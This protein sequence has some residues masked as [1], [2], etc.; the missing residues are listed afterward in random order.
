MESHIGLPV[1]WARAMASMAINTPMQAARSSSKTA[2]AVGS[3]TD[4]RKVRTSRSPIWARTAS[5]A[6]MKTQPSIT[7]EI[8]RT[9][10]T[11]MLN[12]SSGGCSKLWMPW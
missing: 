5:R 9:T 10:K 12:S 11:Q 8:P 2:R 6:F 4:L 3:V 7:K 1:H